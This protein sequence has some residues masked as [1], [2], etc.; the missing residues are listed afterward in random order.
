M[1][2]TPVQ[3]PILVSDVVKQFGR[4]AALRGVSAEFD[5]AKFHAILG[6]NGAGKT[7]LLRALA[8]LAQPTQG[9]ITIF[10]SA[11]QDASRHIGYMAHPSLLYDE[12]SGIENL[13]YFAR[14][15]EIAGDERCRNVIAAVGLDPELTRP[16]GQYSQGMRQRMS[17]ARAILHDPDLLLLD[18]PFSNVDVHSARAMVGLLKGMRDAG[19][20]IF[21]VTHQAILLEGIADEFVWMQEGRIVDRTA[22]AAQPARPQGKLL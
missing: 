15:Y 20:T 12:M 9:S 8:G 19:K 1:I 13:R 2:E 21:V 4:F 3:S 11:P 17:L 18:E 6:D 16:V 22:S 5:A 10:G 14:L 7:T